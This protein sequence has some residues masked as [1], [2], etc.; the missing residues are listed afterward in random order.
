MRDDLRRVATFTS[1]IAEMTRNRAED[2]VKDWVRNGDLRRE[3]AQTLVKDVVDW[4]TSNGKDIAGF[5]RSEI[6]AQLTTLGVAGKSDIERLER[7][8]E[9]LEEALRHTAAKTA[10]TRKPAAKKTTTGRKKATRRKTT[11]AGRATK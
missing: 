6:N 8:V 5:V 10:A 3:Q 9:R 11:G 1:G 7:R 4:S 2:L